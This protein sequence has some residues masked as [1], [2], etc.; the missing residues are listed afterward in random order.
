MATPEAYGSSRAAGLGFE[1]ELQLQAYTTAMATR[2]SSHIFSLLCSLGQY[3]ILN[4]L[5]EAKDQTHM[6]LDTMLGS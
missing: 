1:F 2:D 6:L 3:Q 5:S 4:L